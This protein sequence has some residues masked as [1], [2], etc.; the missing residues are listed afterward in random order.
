MQN[1]KEEMMKEHLPYEFHMLKYSY[2]E[3]SN[4]Q[5]KIGNETN[6]FLEVFLLHARNLI[7]F[8]CYDP[9]KDYRRYTDFIE[10]DDK[11]YWKG[12]ISKYWKSFKELIEKTN[13]KLSHIS[14]KRTHKDK[15]RNLNRFNW[16]FY[17]IDDFEKKEK[18]DKQLNLSKDIIQLESYRSSSQQI[19]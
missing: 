12:N 15:G 7:E 18:I 14:Q 11:I 17:M 4:L 5:W 19:L 8:F 2:K 3:L 13:E 10:K 6:V 9:N 16:L 1:R